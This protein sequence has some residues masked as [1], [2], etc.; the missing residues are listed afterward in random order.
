MRKLTRNN[1]DILFGNGARDRDTFD[2]TMVTDD[3][4]GSKTLAN[5]VG[6]TPSRCLHWMLIPNPP[7]N[8]Q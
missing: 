4:I 6:T 7:E 8:R 1:W 2:V 3:R 5:L